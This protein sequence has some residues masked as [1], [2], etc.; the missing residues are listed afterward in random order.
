[1]HYPSDIVT[2][3]PLLVNFWQQGRC[4]T[5]HVLLPGLSNSLLTCHWAAG[6]ALTILSDLQAMTA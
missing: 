2:Q 4:H 5:I 1:M 6:L 3:K